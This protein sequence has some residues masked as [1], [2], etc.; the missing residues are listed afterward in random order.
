MST[1]ARRPSTMSSTILRL[2]SKDSKFRNC[3]STNSLIH[4]HSWCG[5]YD[6][7]IKW[8]LVL[9][10]RRQFVERIFQIS[11]CWTRRLLLLWARS[12]RIPSSRRRSV[13]RNR[14][15]SKRT[16]FFEED[17]S[18]S[19]ST[20]TFEWLALMMQQW[21]MLIYSLSLFMMIIFRNSIQDGM[22]FY[23]QCQGFHPMISC[24]VCTKLRRRESAQLKTALELYD[25]EIH[26]KISMPNFQKLKTMV[27]RTKDQKLWLRNCD[28]MHGRIETGAVIKNRKGLVVV[29]GGKATCCQW[30]E[31]GQCSKRDQCSFRH[32]S[33]DRAQ[34]P[35]HNAATPSGPTVS[36]GRSASRKRSIRGKSNHGAILRQPCRYYLKGNLHANVLWILASTRV[37]ILRNSKAGDKCL[38]PHHKVEEQ[39]NKK[40][41]KGYYSKKR[42]ESDDKNAVLWKLYHDWVAS[43]KTRK[44]WFLKEAN[45][46]GETRCKKSWE[47]FEKYDSPSLR[48]VKRVSGKSKDHRFEKNKLKPFI[49]EVPTPWNWRTGSMNRLKDN[50]D[51]PEARLGILPKTYTSSKKQTW[52]YSSF[53]RRN[54]YSR[55]RQQKGRRKESLW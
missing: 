31:K 44:H 49:S 32:E 51:V 46:P 4:N 3:T 27:K 6:S 39:P 26:Q 52:L 33:D 19:W 54:G 37:S 1:F 13:S 50:S 34:R 53:S 21:I 10:F 2:D 45:S 8:L 48:Y 23:Y 40:P 5:R 29:E 18:P 47:Q 28:A 30:K 12:Y 36:R 25:M 41:K 11:R 42:R 9:I 22:K 20:T 55:L 16:G 15:P 17:R 24:K 7:K 43:L 14:K 38:F 35:E